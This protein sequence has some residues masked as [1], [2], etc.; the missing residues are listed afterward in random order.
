MSEKSTNRI[1][2]EALEGVYDRAG[3]KVSADDIEKNLETFAIQGFMEEEPIIRDLPTKSMSP[4]QYGQRLQKK[5]R[6]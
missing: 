5:R 1:V 4:K 2:A 6:K 3:Q